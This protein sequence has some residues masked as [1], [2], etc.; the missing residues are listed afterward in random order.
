MIVYEAA[1]ELKLPRA[2]RPR[3]RELARFL[4]RAVE[5][6]G[7]AGEV[8]VLLTGD[9]AIR[10]LNG[11]YRGK[12]KATDVLS[13]PAVGTAE[14]IS[15]DLVISLETALAQAKERGHTLEMEIKVLLLHGLLHLAGYDH[16]TDDGAMHRKE[17]RLRRELGLTAG[18]IERAHPQRAR[19][20]SRR[21]AVLA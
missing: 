20:Q 5:A 19:Q 10:A 8:G 13:F 12:D 18:L 3:R 15:G 4:R 1:V 14:G 9:D 2:A 16:E 21:R 6:I 7:L 11:K 17:R